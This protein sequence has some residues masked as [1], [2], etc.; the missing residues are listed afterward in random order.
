M[1]VV[2][3][4]CG[5]EGSAG[6]LASIEGLCR[7]VGYVHVVC[8]AYEGLIGAA[9]QSEGERRQESVCI[10]SGMYKCGVVFEKW[11]K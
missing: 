10:M 7:G 1:C 8:A 11:K 6:E 2:F 9:G 4:D 5:D 3:L